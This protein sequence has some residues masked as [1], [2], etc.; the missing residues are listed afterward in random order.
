MS[1]VYIPAS[2]LIRECPICNSQI[3]YRRDGYDGELGEGQYCKKC[4]Q[5]IL[6]GGFG[7]FVKVPVDSKNQV[8]KEG[9]K[10]IDNFRKQVADKMREVIE[11]DGVYHK[12]ALK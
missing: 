1:S 11:T 3:R 4:N 12:E 7:L 5:Y 2:S 10:I 6:T 8:T 9:Q